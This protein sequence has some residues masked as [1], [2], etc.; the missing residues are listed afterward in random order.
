MIT[1]ASW[2]VAHGTL[3]S[4]GV[5]PA[6]EDDHS[7]K[8]RQVTPT[9]G[10]SG[11]PSTRGVNPTRGCDDI[12]WHTRAKGLWAEST[13]ELRDRVP[14]TRHSS[15]DSQKVQVRHPGRGARAGH[16]PHPASTLEGSQSRGEAEQ[17]LEYSLKPP[18][19]FLAAMSKQRFRRKFS[20][21]S[22]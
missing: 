8:P 1:A 14:I 7:D 4:G 20:W 3:A 16:A 18:A 2:Q 19:D 15:P 5:N 9:L 11:S 22:E 17:R 13:V 6:V 12:Q 21:E 10:A